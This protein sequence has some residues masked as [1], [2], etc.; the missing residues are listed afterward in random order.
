MSRRFKS[1][2]SNPKH[3]IPTFEK[4]H[5]ISNP[6]GI[7]HREY[8]S[9]VTF[10]QH[11]FRMHDDVNIYVVSERGGKIYQVAHINDLFIDKTC[12]PAEAKINVSWYNHGSSKVVRA[13][14]KLYQMEKYDP[15]IPKERILILD[16]SENSSSDVC[17]ESI[18]CKVYVNH[19][20][21]SYKKSLSP[22]YFC[23]KV[24][25]ENKHLSFYQHRAVYSFHFF[26][27][28]ILNKKL[29]NTTK[30]RKRKRSRSRAKS[31]TSQNN[32]NSGTDSDKNSKRR[33]LNSFTDTSNSDGS[34]DEDDN[35]C[36]E[37]SGD[38]DNDSSA[39]GDNDNYSNENKQ[40]K[41]TK[42]LN[43]IYK[44]N[45]VIDGDHRET[46]QIVLNKIQEIIEN[47]FGRGARFFDV[48]P[49]KCPRDNLDYKWWPTE[50]TGFANPPFSTS[51][52]KKWMQE[53][54]KYMNNGGKCFVFLTKTNPI[55]SGYWFDYVYDYGGIKKTVYA[56]KS[57]F[58]Y[59]GFTERPSF[60]TNL[61]VFEKGKH[62][63]SVEL[64]GVD[65]KKWKREMNKKDY[66]SLTRRM[67]QH[68][69][70]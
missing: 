60:G 34:K 28:Y 54:I 55:C 49:Y 42:A 17:I 1:K 44:R 37:Q 24:E 11:E 25:Y 3:S 48:C 26:H 67:L 43:K 13:N 69:K 38:E 19:D 4:E 56:L 29:S 8:Y 2:S 31:L 66:N 33:K 21:E 62:D 16:L 58:N 47:K 45:K 41:S 22:K 63:G 6:N 12:V 53:A 57:N 40:L 35:E 32:E 70:L 14:E 7:K 61:I 15:S 18:V 27:K 50:L 68:S 20:D 65:L 39:D 59:K 23:N 10:Q 52:P 30:K 9:S 51:N 36:D 5:R 46:P 64:I